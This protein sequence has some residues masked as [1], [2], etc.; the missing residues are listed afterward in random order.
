MLGYGDDIYDYLNAA[1]AI[2]LIFVLS[3]IPFVFIFGIK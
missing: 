2:L 1:F 3:V